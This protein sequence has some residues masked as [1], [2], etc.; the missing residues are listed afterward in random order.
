MWDINGKSA[1][2]IASERER[3]DIISIL[4][5]SFCNLDILDENLFWTPLLYAINSGHKNSVRLLLSAGADPN[6]TTL[7]G[8]SA[9]MLAIILSPT[10][11][12]TGYKTSTEIDYLEM[13]KMLLDSGADPNLRDR[14]GHTALMVA[15]YWEHL[16]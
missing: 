1:L 3:L 11:Q 4:V 8:Q 16:N 14:N 7:E 10:I 6:V 13:V 15:E 2:H 5:S 12:I 9:I